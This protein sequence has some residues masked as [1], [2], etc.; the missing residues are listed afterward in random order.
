MTHDR[1]VLVHADKSALI[2]SVAARFI[3]K[4]AD[5]LHEQGHAHV[6]L[7]GGTVGT[8]VLEAINASPDRDSVDWAKI[9]FW[10]GDER[11]VPRT[12][13]DRN[14]VQARA[15]LLDHIDIPAANVHSFP[16]SDEGLDLDAA[17]DR[18]AAELKT[19]AAPDSLV[20]QF[21]VTFLGVGPDGHIASLFPHMQGIRENDRTV[22][23]VLNSPKPPS[24]RLSLTRWVINSSERIWL[25][26]SGTDKASALGLALA[27]AS[28]DEVPVAGIRGRHYTDFFVDGEAAAEVPEN[29]IAQPH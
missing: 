11:W 6:V 2:D 12:H 9:D 20:P 13:A 26:V 25:V 8:G 21:D 4:M 23:A 7:T 27:G 24:E 17:A 15:A 16:A 18:Y 14:E 10:W 5:I 29:L 3:T 1:R 22:I 28:R 19:Q